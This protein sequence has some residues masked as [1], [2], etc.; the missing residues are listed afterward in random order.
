MIVPICNLDADL[1]VLAKTYGCEEKAVGHFHQS[2]DSINAT[3]RA[4]RRAER[5]LDALR[6]W[7]QGDDEG[8]AAVCSA[9]AAKPLVRCARPEAISILCQL[10]HQEAERPSLIAAGVVPPLVAQLSE[11]AEAACAVEQLSGADG[12]PSA[13][14]SAGG[15]GLVSLAASTSD[16]IEALSHKIGRSRA[17]KA[18]RHRSHAAHRPRRGRRSAHWRP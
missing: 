9:S 8:Q 2:Q 13:I 5:E 14:V 1:P 18:R 16:A 15:I 4:E 10:T 6:A 3:R 17:P 7:R 11:S 12:G